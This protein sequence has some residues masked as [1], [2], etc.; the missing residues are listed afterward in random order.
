M[1]ENG[2]TTPENKV[3]PF[4]PNR[5]PVPPLHNS[6]TS[7][8]RRRAAK[9][10]FATTKSRGFCRRLG[11]C[12]VMGPAST[13]RV[14][15]DKYA[16]SLDQLAQQVEAIEAELQKQK[17]QTGVYKMKLEKAQLF[18]KHCLQVA[19]DNGFLD[20][21]LTKDKDQEILFSPTVTQACIN[22]Q[23][24]TPGQFPTLGQFHPELAPL[25]HQAK[26]NGWYIE[27]QEVEILHLSA[28][29]STADIFRAKW[30]G[31][32]VAVKCMF[33]DFFRSNDNAVGFFAQEVETLSRQRHPFVLQLMGACLDPPENGWIVTEFM[34]TD[35]KEWLHGPGKRQKERT[36]PLPPLKERISKALE[37]AQA[38]QYLH[39]STPKILHRDLKPSNIFLDDAFHVRVADFGHARFLT[40]EEKAMTG[41]TGTF[42]YMAP[43]VIKCEPYDEKC[44]VY[45]FGIML[46]ELI[47]GEYPYTDTDF[48]PSKIAKEVAENG[49]RPKIAEVEE[50]LEGRF[51]MDADGKAAKRGGE[52]GVGDLIISISGEEKD[53]TF[54]F[55][56]AA[57]EQNHRLS[58]DSPSRLSNDSI[59]SAPKSVQMSC[60]SPEFTRFAPSPNK[61]PKIPNCE[62]L[63]RRKSFRKSYSKPKSRFGEQSVAIDSN[64]FENRALLEEHPVSCHGSPITKV[65]GNNAS[66]NEVNRTLSVSPKIPLISSPGG[67]GGVDKDE[68]I[69][70]K[71][72]SR[73]KL[74]YRKV[75]VKVLIEWLLFL[76]IL[77]CLIISLTVEKLKNRTIW[78]LRVSRWCVLV[79][80]TF[81]GM[82][83]TKWLMH[84]IVLLI[85]LNYLLKKKV[86]YFVHGLKKSVQFC[87]W[88]SLVLLTWVLLFQEG[89]KRSRL[90]TRILDFITWS[91]A[92]L[93]IGSFLWVLKTLLLKILASSFHVNT[94]F[95]RIQESTFHQYILMTLS[96]RP[97][98][99]STNVSRLS[100][101]I[102]KK[103]KD[104]KEKKEKKAIDINKLHQMK[105]DKVSAW[106]MKMCVDKISNSGLSLTTL[107]NEIDEG[108]YDGCNEQTD[109]EI[110]N[111]EEAIAA[112]YH[113][114][115][116]VAKPCSMHIYE[117]DLIRFMIKE[118]VEV[119]FPMIDVA[120][121]GKIDRKALIEWV[122][123][124]YNSRKALA[125]A[126]NDTKT[127]VK[128]LNKLVTVVLIVIMIVVWL[129]LTG[130]ATTKVLIFFS[131]QLVLA[132]FVFGNTCRTIFEAIIFVFVMHP[133]DVGDR[134]IIDGTQMIVEEMNILSTV[135]LKFDNEK[136]YYPNNV[137][138]TKPV[139]NFYR[140][141]DMGD[142]FEFCI[143]FKTPFEKIGRLKE[144][145][146]KY[147]ERNSQHWHPNHNMVVKEIENVNKIKMVLFFNHTM[148]FQDFAE[149]CRRRT[150]LVLE[151]KRIFE[152][153][154]ISYGLLPQQVHLV[155][156]K[157]AAAES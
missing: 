47:T 101:F 94:F 85:E 17:Q 125:H 83:V 122:L 43:E 8:R 156:S 81:S 7:G 145:I 120:E 66:V 88:L 23:I 121:T 67:L 114:F 69:Y 134:C 78:D 26:M 153:L 16:I 100:S 127:A 39:E 95:D 75:K 155:E 20:L 79:L 133:F 14:D 57:K 51:E 116:N 5:Q 70:K 138:A 111:E 132:A 151:M 4:S 97:I 42:V 146:K 24:A 141:P 52:I 19:Q 74:K 28:Q 15:L 80:V 135:F 123:K 124:V 82:L 35:L 93:L 58:G 87:I 56:V 109:K 22:P 143:D 72:S 98:L 30:R 139:S 144:E 106:T 140:S 99:E 18:L 12:I 92:S 90:A 61:P 36:V 32:D 2:I 71:V 11:D 64:M 38:M 152:E 33:P 86:L 91:I 104:G 137:L 136:I 55:P 37:I 68:E 54:P 3:I 49:L 77:G 130:V 50:Q 10:A 29:G 45:S 126:L 41:E 96:G 9:A 118:E 105:Q 157:R 102:S 34:T 27:A 107:S 110:T 1:S 62:S 150:D 13:R 46:N 40:D 44:D 21:I 149:R 119:V 60:P 63:T 59:V 103:G 25:V 53:S 142:S 117:L 65:D 131:S 128:Q 154:G 148:N 115:K 73:K 48:G 147:L 84:F 89:V 108:N 31:L 113:I 129:L 112:A 6:S 76:C